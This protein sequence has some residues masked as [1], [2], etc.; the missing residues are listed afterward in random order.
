MERG[1]KRRALTA[2]LS[3]IAAV[4]LCTCVFLLSRPGT[5]GGTKTIVVEVVHGDGSEK[6]FT[7]HTDEEYLGPVLLSDGLIAGE[8]SA[9]GL[10]IITVDG[11]DAV[12]EESGAYWALYEGDEYA[13]Q[14]VDT[15]PV[16]D[17]GQYGLVY[18]VG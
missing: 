9:Y 6:Q 4:A 2:I 18:T 3:L 16:T 1:S 15:T 7:Y 17:G 13:M 12:Y 14:G 5:T 10:Y 8:D 11:E